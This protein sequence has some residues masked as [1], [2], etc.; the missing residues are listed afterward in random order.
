MRRPKDSLVEVQNGDGHMTEQEDAIGKTDK[1]WWLFGIQHGPFL[2]F[3]PP[4]L[5]CNFGWSLSGLL[6]KPCSCHLSFHCGLFRFVSLILLFVQF[7][8]PM[9]QSFGSPCCFAVAS[10]RIFS[11][12]WEIENGSG[13]GSHTALRVDTHTH[14][15]IYIHIN[16]YVCVYIFVALQVSTCTWCWWIIG[17]PNV[18]WNIGP[19]KKLCM[20]CF[21]HTGSFKLSLLITN[22]VKAFKFMPCVLVGSSHA[23]FLSQWPKSERNIT[24]L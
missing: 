2:E 21:R 17:G 3:A 15:Y 10:K 7:S 16:I 11:L 19:R 5:W 13:V 8:T 14:T 18:S 12:K 6:F 1:D 22:L 9:F 23:S 24:H 4:L 20:F